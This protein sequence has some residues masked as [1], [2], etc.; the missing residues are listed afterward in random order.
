[1]SN[2]IMNEVKPVELKPVK[3]VC[4]DEDSHECSGVVEK[5]SIIG[6]SGIYFGIEALCKNSVK[7][8]L[9]MDFTLTPIEA[10]EE[11]EDL[12]ANMKE[13]AWRHP[14][15]ELTDVEISNDVMIER[16]ILKVPKSWAELC[17]EIPSAYS[18][19]DDV[20]ILAR[21]WDRTKLVP[22]IVGFDPYLPRSE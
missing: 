21:A 15:R 19:P 20:Q 1:M 13:K 17:R 16:D 6:K 8:Y 10:P 22:P 18:A 3:L 7:E 4:E 2:V 5:Y 11:K 12:Y 14:D 9:Y